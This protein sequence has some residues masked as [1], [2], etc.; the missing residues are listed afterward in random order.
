MQVQFSSSIFNYSRSFKY[1]LGSHLI[2]LLWQVFWCSFGLR[3]IN[4]PY[5]RSSIRNQ[6]HLAKI[7]E[8]SRDTQIRTLGRTLPVYFDQSALKILLYMLKDYLLKSYAA[9]LQFDQY[10]D[11]FISSYNYLFYQSK[12]E[13]LQFSANFVRKNTDQAPKKAWTRVLHIGSF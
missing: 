9:H 7:R 12:P 4:F 5:H 3:T 8:L 2:I 6:Y 13:I 11:R 1:F 10:R